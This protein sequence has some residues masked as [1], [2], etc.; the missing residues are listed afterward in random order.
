MLSFAGHV[1]LRFAAEASVGRLRAAA[2]SRARRL[3]LRALAAAGQGRVA[4][5]LASDAEAFRELLDDGLNKVTHASVYAIGGLALCFRIDAPLT[6]AV[7]CCAAA[8]GAAGR[9]LAPARRDA[10]A[11]A[12]AAAGEAAALAA[13]GLAAP[14]LV[15]AFGAEDAEAARYDAARARALAAAQ[16]AAV[17][18]QIAANVVQCLGRLVLCAVIAAGALRV[19]SG[20][21]S[22]GDLVSFSYYCLE[23]GGAVDKLVAQVGKVYAALG[24]SRRVVE[25]LEA[26]A[27]FEGE[28]DGAMLAYE[29]LWADGTVGVGAQPA[30]EFDDVRFHYSAWDAV[31]GFSLGAAD[32]ATGRASSMAE[33][34]KSPAVLHGVSFAVRRG[35][36]VSLVGNSGCGKSTLLDMVAR[37]VEPVGGAVY[38]DGVDVRRANPRYARACAS[39]R[40]SE[41]ASAETRLHPLARLSRTQPPSPSTRI[42]TPTLTPTP[43]R[44]CAPPFQRAAREHRVG[45]AGDSAHARHRGRQHPLRRAGGHAYRGRSS[46]RGGG[47]GGGLHR[48][49]R[50]WIRPRGEQGGR[51][52]ERRAVG[53]RGCGA[54][55][56]AQAA[57]AAARRAHVGARRCLR[58]CPRGEPACALPG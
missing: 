32:G 46:G 29:P 50:G 20:A 45:A 17:A 39:E 16:R 8:V 35:E 9:S 56:A 47:G 55:A 7:A 58:R 34:P 12:A 44:A 25:L 13:E 23:V 33:S 53:T 18:E 43:A 31:D 28:D 48:G 52:A 21:L 26:P 27:E 49:A 37:F 15:K 54:C 6:L 41:R 19:R 3:P 5:V 38:V 24:V 57:A 36:V 22:A 4:A 2:L 1:L 51:W 42:L 30:V 14:R 10:A 11:A 40:A